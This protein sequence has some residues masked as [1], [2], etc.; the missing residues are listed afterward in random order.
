MSPANLSGPITIAVVAGE[1]VKQGWEYYL[2]ILAL[3]SVSLGIINLLPIP[4]LDGGHI[5]YGVVEIFTGRPVPDRIQAIGVQVGLFFIGFLFLLAFYND[6]T[7]L[8]S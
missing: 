7:R 2:N 5:L 8:I 6:V 3:L 1:S 4:I